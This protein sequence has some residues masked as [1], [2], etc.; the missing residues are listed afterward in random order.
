MSN[1]C[2]PAFVCSCLPAPRVC[3]LHPCALARRNAQ[4]WLEHEDRAVR[5]ENV[6]N[7]DSPDQ[8]PDAVRMRSMQIN[9]QKKK[10][11]QC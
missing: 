9:N 10:A 2:V 5:L 3:A 1:L 11:A 7:L 8:E 6:S 4:R